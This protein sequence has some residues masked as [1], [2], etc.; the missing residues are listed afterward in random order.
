[1]NTSYTLAKR[2]YKAGSTVTASRIVIWFLIAIILSSSIICFFA[3]K[4]Y[5]ADIELFEHNNIIPTDNSSAYGVDWIGQS[6]TSDNVSHTI[7]YICLSLRKEGAPGTTYGKIR[8]M[9]GASPSGTDLATFTIAENQ[10]GN[11]GVWTQV[12]LS[13]PMTVDPQ[14][15]Y[16]ILINTP[17]GEYPANILQW[18]RSN[19]SVMPF[20]TALAS[21]GGSTWTTQAYDYMFEIWGTVAVEIQDIKVFESYR[22][23]GD[24]LITVR[25]ANIYKPY[26]DSYDIKKYFSLQLRNAS[27]NIT[28][29]NILPAWG[30]R[31][32]CIYLSAATVTALTWGETAYSVHIYGLFNSA[33]LASD[34][35]TTSYWLG[36]DLANLDSWCITSASIIGTYYN[37]DMTTYIAQRGEVLNATGGSI[38]DTG[39][40]GL[41]AIRPGIFQTYSRSGV[42]VPGTYTQTGRNAVDPVTNL[43]PDAVVLLTRIGNIFGGITAEQVATMFFVILTIAIACLAF[44]AGHAGAANILCLPVFIGGLY[45]G[46]NWMF[47]GALGILGAFLIVYNLYLVK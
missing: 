12:S 9:S 1:M 25:Y 11:T 8:K 33:S 2:D 21:T 32:S 14:T 43:G 13:S 4:V 41:S 19:V 22:E 38:F 30:N 17:D 3:Q 16:C 46:V 44:P 7:D 42:N 10:V 34:N 29:Q 26:Y 35:I 18:K 40:P 24:W 37:T 6:F 23:T 45:L 15:E 47:I 27:G 5:A 20:G 31:V 39:I 28:A 36:S